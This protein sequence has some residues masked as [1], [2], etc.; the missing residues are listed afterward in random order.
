MCYVE[1]L[2]LFTK[3]GSPNLGDEF[4]GATGINAYDQKFP[5]IQG[6]PSNGIPIGRD[7]SVAFFVGGDYHG[8]AGALIEGKIVTLGEFI[9]NFGPAGINSLVQGG[10]GSQIIPNNG[11]KIILVGGNLQIDSNVA[12]MQS[13]E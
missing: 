7:D 2:L 13:S 10:S 8:K 4:S 6:V 12:V 1:Q 9:T 3:H 5:N 11:E